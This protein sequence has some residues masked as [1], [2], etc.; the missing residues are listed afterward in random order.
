MRKF[1]SDEKKYRDRNKN[2]RENN[3]FFRNA[4]RKDFRDENFVF[5]QQKTYF[6]KKQE[7]LKQNESNTNIIT[8]QIENRYENI[9][10]E[11]KNDD[12]FENFVYNLFF[13]F[14]GV[15]KKCGII[16]KKFSSNNV[17][18]SHIQNCIETFTF[19]TNKSDQK[20]FS[21]LF[22]IKSIVS[23]VVKN[24]FEFRTYRY[25]TI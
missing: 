22:I 6:G 17:F 23:E 1:N 4:Y 20:K 25:V 11:K 18:H 5:R 16:K 14:L 19:S 21:K 12:E 2:N 9:N 8:N 3:R 7:Y 10:F 24:G 13:E 15:C